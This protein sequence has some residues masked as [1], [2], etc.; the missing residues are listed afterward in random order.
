MQLSIKQLITNTCSHAPEERAEAA[1]EA[2]ETQI[3]SLLPHH[4]AV[5]RLVGV[6]KSID[7]IARRRLDSFR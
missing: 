3:S 6:G 4:H 2:P 7:Q 1:I 5:L